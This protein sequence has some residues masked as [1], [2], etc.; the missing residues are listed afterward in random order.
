MKLCVS[1]FKGP[2]VLLEAKICTHTSIIQFGKRSVPCRNSKQ[3][4][5]SNLFIAEVKDRHGGSEKLLKE[6]RYGR[7]NN[8]HS[9]CWCP[10]F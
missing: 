7:Q 3:L 8:G 10:N 1:S 4:R 6:E 5:G 9:K 2:I